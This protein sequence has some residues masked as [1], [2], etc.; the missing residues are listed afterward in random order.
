M[1]FSGI[2]MQNKKPDSLFART[3]IIPEPS[4]NSVWVIR[5]AFKIDHFPSQKP[6]ELQS[7]K[8]LIRAFCG[9]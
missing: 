3:T 4:R 1:R 7:K 6:S 9:L 8:P 2:A 5:I